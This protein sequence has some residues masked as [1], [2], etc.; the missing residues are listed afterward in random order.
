MSLA[1]FCGQ[2]QLLH[3]IFHN[4][5]I[6]LPYLMLQG[7]KKPH[8]LK[9]KTENVLSISIAALISKAGNIVE[10]E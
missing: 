6:I 1:H 8:Y 10:I 5:Y 2:E 7:R 3:H 9:I 4:N